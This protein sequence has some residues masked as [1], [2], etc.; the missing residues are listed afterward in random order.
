MSRHSKAPSFFMFLTLTILAMLF[1]ANTLLAQTMVDVATDATDPQNLR[2]AE[3]SIAVNP[4]NTKEISI[5]TFSEPWGAGFLAPVWRSIDG[6]VTWRKIRMIAQPPSNG[7][8][9][10]DQHI[11]YDAQGNLY[12]A[13]LDL[14]QSPFKTFDYIYRQNGSGDSSIAGASYGDDQPHVGVDRSTGPC[15]NRIYS[16]WLKV[17]SISRSMV[18]NS[19][20]SGV[21]LSDVDAGDNSAFPN[22]TTRI[23]IAPD[24]KIFIVYKTEEG[25]VGATAPDFE[26]AHF[27][28]L[29][30]DDCGATWAGL[31]PPGTSVHGEANVLTWFTTDFGNL[32]KSKKTNRARSSDAWIAVNPTNGDVYVVHVNRDSSGFG[33][34]YVARSGDHGVTWTSTRVTDGTRNAAFPEIAV[35][36]NGTVGVLYIDYDD[37]GNTTVFRHHFA[38]SY[39]AGGSWTDKILQSMDPGPIEN[40][41]PRS[42]GGG[43][44]WGDYEGLTASGNTFYGVFTGQ[45]IGRSKLQLDPIF[46]TEPATETPSPPAAPSNKE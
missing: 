28:V 32:A 14:I 35:A 15:S 20:N 6:G 21:S 25:M 39:N 24:G 5:V 45:S 18:S 7:M 2:D 12:I 41:P 9:P 19:V 22:R 8:G 46:F 1:G 4:K 38:R 37:S 13:E 11:A 23:A 3:P 34:L 40:A 27:R 16:P 44:I 33:Q 42:D 36:D 30:S 17:G 31:T 10:A 43:F 29:R 26:R